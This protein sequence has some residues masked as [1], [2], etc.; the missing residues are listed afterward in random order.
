VAKVEGAIIVTDEARVPLKQGQHMKKEPK[1]PNIADQFGV[2]TMNLRRFFDANGRLKKAQ[3]VPPEHQGKRKA[4][5]QP[6]LF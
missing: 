6:G 2:K 1:I 3:Y 5:S 4:V